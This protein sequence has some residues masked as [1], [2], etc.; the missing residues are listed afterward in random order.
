MD[1]SARRTGMLALALGAVAVTSAASIAT[2]LTAGGPFGT[3]NDLGN[4]LTAGLGAC[5]AWRL[6]GELPQ[7]VR[8][9]AVGV[10]CL[11]AAVAI[12]G[13]ALVASDTTGWFLGGNVS[14]LGF[15]GVGAWLI[16]FARTA[17][18]AAA[19]PP[20]LRMTGLFAGGLMATGLLALPAIAQRL[21]DP[22][23]AP[24]WA[25]LG[26]IAWLG[27]YVVLPIWAT[28]FGVRQTHV[29]SPAMAVLERT[30]GA[31]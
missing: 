6:R 31:R 19:W 16:A 17:P 1:R 22:A 11:G 20:R 5:L 9:P 21:D 2:Y 23:A 12:A 4:A 29:D 28:W 18:M 8:V 15:A 13:S 10:A 27:V 25:W 30:G 24:A 7:G 3:L 14:S 26:S